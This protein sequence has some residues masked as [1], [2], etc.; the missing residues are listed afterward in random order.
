MSAEGPP[1]SPAPAT[2]YGDAGIGTASARTVRTMRADGL[3]AVRLGKCYLFDASDVEAFI[4]SRKETKCRAQT[5]DRI[6]TTSRAAVAGIS[7]GAKQDAPG[8]SAQAL[9]IA[10]R[11][12]GRSAASSTSGDELNRKEGRVIRGAFP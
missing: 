5:V 1:A 9:E 10:Q 11:L 3:P 12:K 8:N 6:S 2:P 7:S 4:Q